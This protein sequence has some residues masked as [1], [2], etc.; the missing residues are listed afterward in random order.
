MVKNDMEGDAQRGAICLW[1]EK[2]VAMCLAKHVKRVTWLLC[3]PDWKSLMLQH[4]VFGK[5]HAKQP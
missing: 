2:L 5:K 3:D 4:I 1:T